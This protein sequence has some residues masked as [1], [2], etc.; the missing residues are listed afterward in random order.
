MPL[1]HRSRKSVD[2]WWTLPFFFHG[3]GSRD[4]TQLSG[5]VATIVT[6]RATLSTP[7]P[8]PQILKVGSRLLPGVPLVSCSVLFHFL[9]LMCA[10]EDAVLV[11][12]S[13][14]QM[15]SQG[16]SGRI[17]QNTACGAAVSEG[18]S[19][20]VACHQ[21]R[22]PRLGFVVSEV[23][24]KGSFPSGRQQLRQGSIRQAFCHQV[25]AQVLNGFLKCVCGEGG[26]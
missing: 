26:V 24:S 21:D 22:D 18:A 15:W 11:L 12:L 16:Q 8:Q 6:C 19:R 20:S 23:G 7:P 9:F 2:S 10:T 1:P 4:P 17:D 25:T 13:T 14:Y 3:V 5:L